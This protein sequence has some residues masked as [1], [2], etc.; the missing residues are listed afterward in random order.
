[1]DQKERMGNMEQAYH[2]VKTQRDSLRKEVELLKKRIEWLEE[3][4]PTPSDK[5][6]F[7]NAEEYREFLKSINPDMYVPR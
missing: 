2:R 4:L 1:M 6:I 3:D 5:T 7:Q